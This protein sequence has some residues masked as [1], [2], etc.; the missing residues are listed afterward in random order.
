[1]R[2]NDKKN[3][4]SKNGDGSYGRNI[5]KIGVERKNDPGK[6]E[7]VMFHGILSTTE[8]PKHRVQGEGVKTQS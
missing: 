4:V 3:K 2:L 8:W 5:E 6:E 7:D 1:M